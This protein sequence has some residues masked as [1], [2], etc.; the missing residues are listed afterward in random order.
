MKKGENA[1]SR[2]RNDFN[3]AQ[4]VFST[5][6]PFLGINEEIC[7]KVA[8]PFGGGMGRMQETCGAVTGAFMVIG[9]KYGRGNFDDVIAKEKT[10]ELV[11]E[12]VKRFKSSND[13]I[14][15]RELLGCDINTEAGLKKAKENNL[16]TTLCEKLVK[17][18]VKI[19][20]DIL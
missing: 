5:F 16:F 8:C 7:L 11:N 3:C 20:E 4:A 9:L 6:G 1:I 12:F 13:S 15:C 18:A 2:F 19:L 10:Y 17:D 14:N